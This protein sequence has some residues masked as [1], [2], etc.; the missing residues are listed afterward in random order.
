[1]TGRLYLVFVFVVGWNQ[2]D[3]L[4]D[5]LWWWDW[6]NDHWNHICCYYSSKGPKCMLGPI[7]IFCGCKCPSHTNATTLITILV[8]GILGLK[9]VATSQHP[10]RISWVNTSATILVVVGIHG[11]KVS[12]VIG[13]GFSRKLGLRL[14]F[15]HGQLLGFGFQKHVCWRIYWRVQFWPPT[16]PTLSLKEIP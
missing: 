4:T 3:D 10:Y 6:N 15:H 14:G 9:K 8:W 11:Y 13:F 16:P 5:P 12:R 2:V 1:M 7:E